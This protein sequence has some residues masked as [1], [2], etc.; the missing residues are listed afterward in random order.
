MREL[1]G[2]VDCSPLVPAVGV[3]V[4]GHTLQLALRSVRRHEVLEHTEVLGHIEVL[5]RIEVL[6]H[7]EVLEVL[8]LSS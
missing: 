8:E 7:I 6:E 4:E 1:V 2:N 3:H 5:E